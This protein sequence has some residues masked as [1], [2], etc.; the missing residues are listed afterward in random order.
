MHE[1]LT[2]GVHILICVPFNTNFFTVIY[3][4]T[5][6]KK[7]RFMALENLTREI[8][9]RRTVVPEGRAISRL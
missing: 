2:V 6:T 5:E 3:K 1:H 4:V 7:T 9:P 8:E